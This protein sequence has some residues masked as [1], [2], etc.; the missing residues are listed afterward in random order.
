M[1]ERLI[2]TSGKYTKMQ[3]V[4]SFLYHSIVRQS[5][6]TKLVKTML[7]RIIL[8]TLLICLLVTC[9]EKPFT[10]KQDVNLIQDNHQV[11]SLKA[12]KGVLD[13]S[14]WNFSND[15]TINLD[16]QWEFYWNEFME[17]TPIQNSTLKIPN[18]IPVPSQWQRQD[19]PLHGFATYRLRV[20]LTKSNP[21][22][23]IA[24][25]Y[26]GTAHEVYINGKLHSS[27]GTV[28][29]SKDETIPFFKFH[30]FTIEDNLNELEILI[31]ISNF[32]YYKAGL[33]DNI[34]LGSS[35][36][37]NLSNKK[38][39][40]IDLITFSSLMIMGLYHF[41][42]YYSRRK[43]ISPLYFSLCC[44][45]LAF[46]TICI[47]ERII[48]DAFQFLPFMIV[49]KIEY[50]S[51]TYGS[52]L[53]I[54]FIHS[55]FPNEASKLLYRLFSIIFIPYAFLIVLTPIGVYSYSSIAVQ[56][57][58]L[59]MMIYILSITIIAVI[60]KRMG[61]KIFLLGLSI[62]FG[63]I[64][65]D[66]FKSM[67]L[68]F[69][70]FLGSYG[71]LTFIIFQATVL[72]L[73]F[74]GAFTDSENL[75][76]ELKV[77]SEKLEEKVILRTKELE[78]AKDEA[79][80]EKGIAQIARQETESERHKSEKLLLSILPKEVVEELK[81]KGFSEPVLFESA[82]VLFT[83]FKGFTIIAETL[84]PKELVEELDRSFSYFDS[85]MER[86]GI[87]KLKTIG[88]SYMCAGGI[89]NKNR[90]HAIDCVLV[91]LEIQSIMKKVKEYKEIVGLPYW[92]LRL[93][94]HSGSIV[95]GVIG[96]KK[97]AY[98]VWGDAVN[99]ASRMESSGTPGKINISGATYLLV[100]S[101]F[102]CEYRGRVNAKNKG[103]VDMYYVHGIKEEYSIEGD[104][105]TP[106]SDFWEMYNYA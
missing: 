90:T 67:G 34:K 74:A 36:Q 37:I 94:I 73:K 2:V 29:K 72:S 22:L 10:G 28:G 12:V 82:S 32:H 16:G 104:G 41:G 4:N 69:F 76:Q 35:K 101:L 84:S 92:E 11:I 8:I 23:S 27:I 51:F 79:E 88:D 45:S 105:R 63:T 95:A 39:F 87:E 98:D 55:L 13:L 64:T 46:R 83:D 17:P 100:K 1:E 102:E 38:K 91:A 75:A 19:Y 54:Q 47:N 56:I 40:V 44:L 97:F 71:L 78:L 89:P 80:I 49:H 5:S 86:Y 68:L 14:T 61:S 25:P 9:K 96:E 103:E 52:F 15:G 18:Y 58:L 6:P 53:F 66:I 65:M 70:P 99:T 59:L 106:N 30:T 50:I 33:W 57:I 93:G 20:L 48:M 21:P 60:R 85:L 62:F 31:H 24:M 81:E 43:D 26:A 7:S 77:F 3:N 42:L